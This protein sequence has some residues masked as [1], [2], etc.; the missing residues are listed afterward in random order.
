MTFGNVAD[1]VKTCFKHKVI[2]QFFGC[3]AFE[4]IEELKKKIVANAAS[5][6]STLGGGAH[7]LMGVDWGL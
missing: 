5:V 7:G 4:Q 6:S 1:Y 3:P 2:P